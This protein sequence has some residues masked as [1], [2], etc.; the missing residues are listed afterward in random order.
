M[1]V[2]IWM[3]PYCWYAILG[4]TL[5]LWVFGVISVTAGGT[6]DRSRC[7]KMCLHLLYCSLSC[8]E[9]NISYRCLTTAQPSVDYWQ[10]L[11]SHE[12]YYILFI[13][14][15]LIY[16]Y[17]YRCL[18]EAAFSKYIS[19]NWRISENLQCTVSFDINSRQIWMCCLIALF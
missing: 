16:S 17:S 2:D 9:S 8:Q 12:I 1:H 7:P 19:V 3:Q 11:G 13:D 4:T 10:D 15:L 18:Y 14:S 6:W 5:G